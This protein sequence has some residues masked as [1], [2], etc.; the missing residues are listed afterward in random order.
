M[1]LIIDAIINTSK[2]VKKN[3]EVVSIGFATNS[4]SFK[5][6]NHTKIDVS[7]LSD[8]EKET[9]KKFMSIVKSK[10]K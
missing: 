3:T 9:V 7:S 5:I 8:D 6:I 4:D 2:A 10:F 1:S